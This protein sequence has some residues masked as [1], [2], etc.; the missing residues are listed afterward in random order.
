MRQRAGRE[1][2]GKGQDG[3]EK[4]EEKWKSREEKRKEKWRSIEGGETQHTVR[5]WLR[6]L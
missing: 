3:G 2:K 5:T 1:R 6:L 4:E